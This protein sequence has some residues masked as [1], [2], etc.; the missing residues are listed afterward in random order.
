MAARLPPVGAPGFTFRLARSSLTI[1]AN[2][3]SIS[4]GMT[5]VAAVEQG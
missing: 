4:P 3:A 5:T 2:M 1:S